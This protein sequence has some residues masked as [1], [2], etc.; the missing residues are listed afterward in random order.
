M[1]RVTSFLMPKRDQQASTF[2]EMRA[3]A[4][5]KPEPPV[6]EAPPAET[7]MPT[8]EKKGKSRPNPQKRKR[9][10]REKAAQ[11]ESQKEST[12]QEESGPTQGWGKREDVMR[13]FL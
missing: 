12:Q 4:I 10:N 3:A 6:K 8:G 11:Q 1:T 9:E 5:P 13:E 2:E 7:V